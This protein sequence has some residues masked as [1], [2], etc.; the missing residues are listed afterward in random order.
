MSLIDPYRLAYFATNEKAMLTP[1]P[2]RKSN[3]IIQETQLYYKVMMR[4][5]YI[6][7]G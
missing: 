7:S 1:T 4:V 2:V 5:H 6:T 3:Q